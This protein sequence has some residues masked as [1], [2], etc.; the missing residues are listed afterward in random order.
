MTAAYDL[1]ADVAELQAVDAS[2]IQWPSPTWRGRHL[3]FARDVMGKRTIAKHQADI[4]DAYYGPGRIEIGVCTGQKLGKTEDLIIIMG[5]D[6]AI[7]PELNF[8]LF[9]PTIDWIDEAIWPRFVP[10]IL[11][12]YYPCRDCMPAHRA[13]CALVEMDPFDKTPRPERCPNCSPLIP[14]ELKDPRDPSKGRKSD[15]LDEKTCEGGLRD[16]SKKRAIRGYTSIK[17]GGKGG[18][19]G[20]VR[21]ACD[22]SSDVSDVT[23]ETIRGNM[24]GGGKFI[25]FGNLL[26][27]SGWFYRLFGRETRTAWGTAPTGERIYQLSSR[28]SPN[29][30]GTIK[31]S[32]GVTTA[33]DNA[34]RPIPGMA[35][36]KDIEAL[37]KAWENSK[38][39]IDARIDAKAPSIVAGQLADMGRVAAAEKRWTPNVDGTGILQLGVDVARM[40]DKLAIAVR[41]G[42]TIVEL[43]AEALGQDDHV[44][45][46]ELVLE[47]GRKHRRPHERK[48]RLVYDQTGP[49]GQAFRKELG[50]Q[51]ADEVF[52]IFPIQMGAPPS[53]GRNL[54]DKRRDQIACEFADWLKT[55]AIPMNAALEAQ[56]EVTTAKQVEVSYG[57][58]GE[59]WTVSRLERTNDELRPQLGGNSP[60]ELNACQLAAYDVDG[61]EAR[62]SAPPASE[63]RP[64]AEAAAASPA[65]RPAPANDVHESM[66]DLDMSDR[67][68]AF[69][70]MSWGQA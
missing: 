68:D 28:Y 51:K 62:E 64:V 70:R 18:F 60:D 42:N 55:G 37:L 53:R 4:L 22:E 59:K 54:Y 57:S 39:Y 19:S 11:A 27:V 15:W 35:T 50:A 17:E 1:F 31:W 6:W 52:D 47:Y 3:E 12:A 65:V 69:T 21:F 2:R 8:Y 56:I 48:P 34:S 58:K 41:R 40:R 33:N 20:N 9:G 29:C 61:S 16:R 49:E 66:D 30:Q 26:H 38:N 24:A 14:S 10:D 36:R 32:D 44:R 67:L 13:W 5:C 46:V 43:F 23:R 45:G 7:E 63:A 25:A